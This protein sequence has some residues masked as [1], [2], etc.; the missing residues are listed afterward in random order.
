MLNESCSVYIAVFDVYFRGD[1]YLLEPTNKA[2]EPEIV[3]VTDTSIFKIMKMVS[4]LVEQKKFRCLEKIFH[5]WISV[6]LWVIISPVVSGTFYGS[7]L[8]K[9]SRNFF[10]TPLWLIFLFWVPISIMTWF[11]GQWLKNHVWK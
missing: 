8:S 9:Y 4:V 11:G 7:V 3:P 5:V 2:F 6:F 10:F 1:N